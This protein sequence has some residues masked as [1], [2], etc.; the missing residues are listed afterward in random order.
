MFIAR[1]D[2]AMT[3]LGWLGFLT[4]IYF[5]G[6]GLWL[7]QLLWR[8]SK[9][10][11]WQDRSEIFSEYRDLHQRALENQTELLEACE[12]H[13]T[14]LLQRDAQLADVRAQLVARKNQV[15]AQENQLARARSASA[16]WEAA[17]EVDRAAAA[18]KALQLQQMQEQLR[19]AEATIAEQQ[20]AAD[21]QDAGHQCMAAS[22]SQQLAKLDAALQLT[23]SDAKEAQTRHAQS[24][25]ELSALRTKFAVLTQQLADAE[26]EQV[27]MDQVDQEYNRLREHLGTL[28]QQLEATQTSLADRDLQCERLT[29]ELQLAQEDLE[30]RGMLLKDLRELQTAT[31]TK[32]NDARKTDEALTELQTE[33]QRLQESLRSAESELEASRQRERAAEQKRAQIGQ[34]RNLAAAE[35][36]AARADDQSQIA[37]LRDQLAEAEARLETVVQRP[38][39]ANE[40]TEIFGVSR[41]LEEQLNAAGVFR[42]EQMAQWT[43]RQKCQIERQ[44][45]LPGR[46][47]DE[48]WC[49]QAKELLA[50][51]DDS[52]EPTI[53]PEKPKATSY[54]RALRAYGNVSVTV[55]ET[56]GVVFTRRPS[57]VDDLTAVRGIGQVNQRL[58]RKAGVYRLRQ[59]ADWNEYNVWA[60]NALLTFKGRIERENWVGQAQ[61]LL[62]SQTDRIEDHA[63]S[64]RIDAADESSDG[65]S[66]RAAA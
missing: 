43:N 63:V 50:A 13:E 12:I 39:D 29:E 62:A 27:S 52:A 18:E 31:V 56:L 32:L 45:G 42:F 15:D 24:A 66:N 36:E 28:R 6:I 20:L 3:H 53:E 47:R 44:L 21:K 30:L 58:L 48:K 35:A 64:I 65:E 5:A 23:A 41:R 54:L 26:N 4:A 19:A 57:Y 1:L 61:D 7:A 2:Y 33:H 22:W 40:L 37:A 17:R 51:M 38:E 11:V 16:E 10:A 46:V 9:A 55:D 60:F 25:R 49:D 14:S 34:Q 8:R 59:I